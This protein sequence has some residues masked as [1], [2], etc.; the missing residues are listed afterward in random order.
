M[1]NIVV[2]REC[3]T[4]SPGTPGE[5]GGEGMI[6]SDRVKTLT[7]SLSHAYMGEGVRESSFLVFLKGFHMSDKFIPNAD[8]D[9]KG[10]AMN[11]AS[12]ISADPEKYFV[13]KEDADALTAAVEAFLIALQENYGAARNKI[14]AHKK[15]EARAKVEEIIRRLAHMIRA[16]PKIDAA[17]KI[18]IRIKDRAPR[19]RK[20]LCPLDPPKLRFVRALHEANGASPR[21]ELRFKASDQW[22]KAKPD[23]AVRL[24]LFVD[25]IPPDAPI[26]NNPGATPTGRPWYLRSFTKSPIVIEPP[27]ARVP[28]R[29]VYWAR[30]ADST[31]NVSQF[32]ATAVGWIEGGNVS[33]RGIAFGNL[34]KGVRPLVE[35]D[36]PKQLMDESTYS[37]AVMEAHYLTVN[38][39]AM[40]EENP[41][42]EVTVIKETKQIEGPREALE[43]AA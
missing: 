11:F 12:K 3:I 8:S 15:S 27:M 4:P 43:D 34:G 22:N 21:H 9:F 2:G 30:W 5:G 13:S 16:N 37:I 6:N 7:P 31:G 20:A 33:N 25:L 26:P 35:V 32:S 1:T 42:L 24:E 28:M 38:T 41:K 18:V 36:A 10:M 17:A 29:V 40:R 19:S 23:G 39:S 14:T